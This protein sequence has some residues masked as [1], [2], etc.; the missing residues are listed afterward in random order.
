MV[1][2]AFIHMESAPPSCALQ[3]FAGGEKQE[4]YDAVTIFA[5][6]VV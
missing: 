5:A 3:F 4:K 1:L 6:V 2:K